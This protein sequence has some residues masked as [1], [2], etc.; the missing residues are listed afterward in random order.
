MT[1]WMQKLARQETLTASRIYG[2][3]I[4]YFDWIFHNMQVAKR[5]ELLSLTACGTDFPLTIFH[6]PFPIRYPIHYES[7]ALRNLI[8]WQHLTSTKAR[9]SGQLMPKSGNCQHTRFGT[10]LRSSISKWPYAIHRANKWPNSW[11]KLERL[12]CENTWAKW[13]LTRSKPIY[14]WIGF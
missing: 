14:I 13:V 11:L 1:V 7:P 5:E 8:L 2:L 12:R 9:K 3:K 10:R 4:V 6:F